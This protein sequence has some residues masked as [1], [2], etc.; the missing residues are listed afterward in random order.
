MGAGG[1]RQLFLLWWTR[2]REGGEGARNKRPAPAGSNLRK[3]SEPLKAVSSDGKQMFK[4][5]SLGGTFQMETKTI[6]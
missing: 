1:R 5:T 4:N 6:I 3:F 2:E